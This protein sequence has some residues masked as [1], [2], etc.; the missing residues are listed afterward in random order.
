MLNNAMYVATYPLSLWEGRG[1][2]LKVAL[3]IQ[4][5]KVEVSFL[6]QETTC[7]ICD[8]P[9]ENL[10]KCSTNAFAF[11]QLKT[12]EKNTCV[13]K[14]NEPCVRVHTLVHSPAFTAKHTAFF[15]NAVVHLFRMQKCV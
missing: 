5:M 8:C 15:L 2:E 7:Q 11:E 12:K 9:C 14:K 3:D 10:Y 4:I 6:V 13:F 1:C